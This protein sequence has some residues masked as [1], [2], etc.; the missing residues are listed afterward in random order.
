[1]DLRRLIALGRTW[2]PLM[3]VTAVLAGAT[4]FVV[5]SLQ[6][7]VYEAR[8]TLIVGQAL[9]ATNPDYSQI[10]VAQNLATTY[11]AIAKTT[12]I[13]QDVIDTLKLELTPGELRPRINVES[14]ADSTMLFV[15]AQDTDPEQAAV[16]ANAVGKALIAASPA[17]Q[18]REAEFQASIDADLAATQDLIES[19]QVRI[20]AL[21]AV[22]DRTAQQEAQLTALEARLADLR[23]TYATLLSFSSGT[24][25]NLLTVVEPAGVPDSPIAPRTL[26]NTLLAAALG[27]LLVAAIAFLAEQLD[28]SIRDADAVQEVTGLGTLGQIARMRGERGR[29]EIYRLATLLYPRSGVAEGF[30]SLRANVEFASVDVPLRTLLVTSA[31]PDEGKTV[32]AA[33]LAVVFAQAG[34]RVLLVDADLRKPSVHTIFALPNAHGL[35]SMLRS[36]TVTVDAVAHASEQANL[37]V[38]TTGPLPPNPAELLGSHRMQAV[39]ETLQK[40]ADLIVFDSP[41]LQAV[42]D[43]AVLSSFTDGAILVVDARSSRRRS[44][45]QAKE[46]LD[47][48]GARILGI[49]LNRVDRKNSSEY[50]GYYGEEKPAGNGF[51]RLQSP[52][53]TTERRGASAGAEGRG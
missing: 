47:R 22:D 21:R 45:R 33:N 32:T 24:A 40:S 16:L 27:L 52:D 29:S 13:L 15:Y 1:V 35:T 50:S 41:P 18:G 51:A 49:V 7:N 30:R 37:R 3:L 43:A 6:R 20:E 48:A 44:V 42:T 11:A 46:T 23:S 26:F 17:I 34:R 2:L 10:L 14:P 31:V 9:S 28:D 36:E 39:L 53:A 5:S 25:T 4:A 19:T 8:E 38:L 12:P